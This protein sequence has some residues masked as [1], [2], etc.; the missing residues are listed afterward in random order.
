[1]LKIGSG[2]YGQIYRPLISS[3]PEVL[4]LQPFNNRRG[5]RPVVIREI[6]ILRLLSQIDSPNI[7]QFK[8]ASF[9]EGI[10]SILLESCSTDLTEYVKQYP[11]EIR[12]KHLPQLIVDVLK[13]LTVLESLEINHLDLKPNNILVSE[14]NFKITDFGLSRVHTIT[15]LP[16]SVYCSLYRP[17]ERCLP[18]KIRIPGNASD[19]WAFGVILYFYVTGSHLFSVK[20]DGSDVLTEIY[21]MY[22]KNQENPPISF[23]WFMDNYPLG[24][25]SGKIR[26]NN[27]IYETPSLDQMF[28]INPLFRPRP[29]DF[30]ESKDRPVL[31]EKERKYA[32]PI[33]TLRN[34]SD[35]GPT[36]LM[37]QEI[38][39]R[40]FDSEPDEDDLRICSYIAKAFLQK[41][42][43]DPLEDISIDSE[44][45]FQIM[46]RLDFKVYSP[47]LINPWN[48]LNIIPKEEQIGFLESLP[49]T[50]YL[51][52]VSDWFS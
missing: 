17:P 10:F 11:Y 43:V 21:I 24:R 9:S 14:K 50:E 13:G 47:G 36:I 48:R 2:S 19:V 20:E 41:E 35:D 40:L 31:E 28:E 52:P 34:Y 30:L 42:L 6:S 33:K 4:K 27:I 22:S 25:I 29:S 49:L 45:V 12:I 3:D 1:M 16:H 44:R 7:V 46:K 37:I 32:V 39:G 23:S 18:F 51:I 8:E 26:F 5:V 15:P 38:I